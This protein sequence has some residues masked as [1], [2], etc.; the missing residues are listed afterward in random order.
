M[1]ETNLRIA[2]AW[3][4]LLAEA[5]RGTVTAQQTL[6]ALADGGL[7]RENLLRGVSQFLPAGVPAPSADTVEQ[8]IEDL[9]STAGVVPRSRHLDLLERHEALRARLEEAE[10]TI[11]RLKQKA[12]EKGEEP[13]AQSLLDVYTSAVGESLKAPADWMRGWLTPTPEAP[14]DAAPDKPPARRKKKPDGPS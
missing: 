10:V 12:A 4:R 6:R 11:Q 2:E 8:W 14:P 1:N 3:F 9:W 13:A 7:S 5:A